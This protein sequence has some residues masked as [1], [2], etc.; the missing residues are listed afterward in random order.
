MW[1]NRSQEPTSNLTTKKTQQIG[2]QHVVRYSAVPL[3]RGQ[4]P[5]KYSLLVSFVDP[6]SDWYSVS[7]PIIINVIPNNIGPHYNGTQLY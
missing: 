1:V 2:V 6:A 3:K 5:H 4:F 7:I